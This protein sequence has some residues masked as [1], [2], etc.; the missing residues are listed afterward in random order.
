MPRMLRMPTWLALGALACAAQ[1][2]AAAPA[3][4]TFVP[5]AHSALVTLEAANTPE[6]L[7]LRVRRTQAGAPL[8]LTQFA[9]SIDGTSAAATPRGDGSWLVTWPTAGAPRD[10]K[11]EAVITHDGI[12]EVLSG[13][14]PAPVGGAPGGAI[15][16]RRQKQLAWWIL[17][18][19]IVLIAA[20]A[21]SRRMS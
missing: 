10:G 13:A 16:G 8:S 17:N 14:V 4:P 15:G 6:G 3:A 18:I 5:V 9:V 1:A 11:L 21:I 2:W 7:Q 20:I 12:R 19:V